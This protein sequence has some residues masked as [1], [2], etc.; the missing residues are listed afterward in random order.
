MPHQ[1]ITDPG[2]T[3]DWLMAPVD[4]SGDGE[5]ADA[6][7]VALGTDALAGPDDA[8]PDPNNDDRRGWWGDLDAELLYG[9]WPIG[10]RIWLMAREK[11]TGPEARQGSTIGKAEDIVRDALQPFIDRRIATHMSVSAVRSGLEQIDVDVTLFRGAKPV[12]SLRYAVL[13]SKIRN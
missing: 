6:V 7:V 2:M 1:V 9:G 12:V 13:W 4:E 8:L 5:L 11:I 3:L 10:S